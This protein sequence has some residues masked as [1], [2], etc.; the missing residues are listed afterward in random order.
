MDGNLKKIIKSL[1][2]T[3]GKLSLLMLDIDFFKRY[4]DNYGHDMGD[5]CLKEVASVLS[6]CITRKDDFVA[7]YGGEEFVVVLPN[8]DKKG[9]CMIAERLLQR[10]YQ[11]GIPHDKSDAAEFVTVSIGVTTGIVK[12]SQNGTDYVKCADSALYKSKR[13]GRN[14][15]TFEAFGELED[16]GIGF[17]EDVE[18]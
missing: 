18:N 15:Y 14:R 12:Y 2:R 11:S 16:N 8:T 1:S 10:V 9:A 4:N 5:K 13:G 17:T 6:Q 7:R 3:D